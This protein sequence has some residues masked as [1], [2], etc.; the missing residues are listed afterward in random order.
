MS[1]YINS[2]KAATLIPK[3]P[4]PVTDYYVTSFEGIL[5]GHWT[6]PDDKNWT[7]TILYYIEGKNIPF[8]GLNALSKAASTN[9]ATKN[10]YSGSSSFH[11]FQDYNSSLYISPM[12]DYTIYLVTF[13]GDL[14]TE[15]NIVTSTFRTG[16]FVV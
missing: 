10:K 12:A 9:R 15:K 8:P 7:E 16:N 5:G 6:D 14:Y 2:P 4:G 13:Y 1:L 3:L 11:Y